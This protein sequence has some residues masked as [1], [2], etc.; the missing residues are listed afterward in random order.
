VYSGSQG[1]TCR[2]VMPLHFYSNMLRKE[3]VYH[4][5]AEAVFNADPV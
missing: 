2:L 3:N 1:D 5:I 4:I